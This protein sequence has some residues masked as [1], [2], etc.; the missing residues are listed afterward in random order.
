MMH[1]I[2]QIGDQEVLVSMKEKPPWLV[3]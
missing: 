1:V 2:K 3:E